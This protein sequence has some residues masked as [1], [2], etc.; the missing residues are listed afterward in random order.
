MLAKAFIAAAF[1]VTLA[2]P[3]ASAQDKADQK[4]LTEAI[5][6]NYAEVEMGKLAQQKGQSDAVK[7]F[8]QMLVTDHSAA[9][10]KAIAAAKQMGMTP[11]TGPSDK[12][13]A[14]HDKMA[15]MSGAD[16]DRSFA[17]DMVADHKKDI[18]AYEKAA[19]NKDAAG[20]YASASLPTLHKHLDAAEKI[21]QGK[22]AER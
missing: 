14:D 15:K 13:K 17:R 12:Q 19:K 18:Q 4:F 3:V 22:S 7:S 2:V 21:E 11:P 9:N 5:Q 10:E 8:G 20:E 6:G 16:F 1:A